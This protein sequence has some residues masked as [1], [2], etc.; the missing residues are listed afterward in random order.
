[1]PTRSRIVARGLERIHATRKSEVKAL[2]PLDLEVGD[3]EFLSI[4]GPSGCGKSTFLRLI[5][6]LIRPTAGELDIIHDD[7]AR[8]LVSIVFQDHSIFPW[9]TVEENVRTALTMATNLSK[10]EK[11]ARVDHWVRRMGLA[12]FA[13]TYP[14][15]LSGGMRQRVSIAR[16]MAVDPEVLL[17]D[18]PFA[19]LDAQMRTILQDELIALWEHDRRTVVFITHALDEAIFLGDR[20]VIMSAR[21]GVVR[22]EVQVPFSRPRTLDLR[23]TPEFAALVQET[24][25]ILR[26]EVM[27]ELASGGAAS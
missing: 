27:A 3:G 15:A 25:D 26:D 20:V 19:S 2:G 22:A 6:G 8:H 7:T 24:W 1:V 17:M 9:Q 23:G 16:A 21:P 13:G 4:V 10:Q 11:A 12:S 14:A 18:E 5:A